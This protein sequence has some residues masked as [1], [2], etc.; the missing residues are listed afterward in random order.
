M[1]GMTELPGLSFQ[2]T[3]PQPSDW[4]LDCQFVEENAAGLALGALDPAETARV[5]HHLSWCPGCARL[6]HDMRTTVGYLPYTSVQATPSPAVK[7]RLFDRIRAAE[8][9]GVAG[10]VDLRS[11]P[12]SAIQVVDAPPVRLTPSIPASRAASIAPAKKRMTWEMIVAP[13]AAVP[14]V[15]ALAIVGGWAL[16]TQERLNDQ[17]AQAR[18]LESE[19]ADLSAQVSLLSNGVG[20]SQT[21]RFV[22][23]A[24]DSIIGGSTASG[25]LV[26]IVN[27]PWATLSVW[28]LP[29]SANGYEVT[30]ET[31]QGEAF[32]V[33][34]FVVD[35]EGSAEVLLDIQRPLEDYRAVHISE[36]PSPE[37][38]T[39][40]D[41]LDAEDVLWIDMES[42]LGQ[43]GG[44]EAN[45]KAH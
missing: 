3:F 7:S 44:T 15:V 22:L 35:A 6:V 24:P 28:N 29:T 36:R 26:G 20:D 14:L 37:I 17:V 16:R 45:A 43:P 2:A 9:L 1:S 40:N 13:L 12:A 33:G 8:T 21:R 30:I 31:K 10:S 11:L 19:N 32:S 4:M 38:T 23:D 5:T 39:S 18:N 25:T 27:Q 41:S 42:N 34:E